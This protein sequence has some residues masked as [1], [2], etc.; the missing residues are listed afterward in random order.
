VP[1]GEDPK[2][3]DPVVTTVKFAPGDL[4]IESD[5]SF[6]YGSWINR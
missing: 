2:L 3:F 4:Y 6:R 5:A 1:H